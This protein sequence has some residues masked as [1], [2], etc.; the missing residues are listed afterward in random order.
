[1]SDSESGRS[2]RPRPGKDTLKSKSA[3]RKPVTNFKDAK[4]QTVT[5]Y[6]T[7]SSQTET[8]PPIIEARPLSKHFCTLCLLVSVFVSVAIGIFHTDLFQLSE[9]EKKDLLKTG[10]LELHLEFPDVSK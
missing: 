5:I 6:K 4:T 3:S 7:Q 10:M 1:M 9:S 8:Q 2:L